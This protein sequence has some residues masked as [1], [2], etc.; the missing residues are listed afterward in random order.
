MALN[1]LCTPGF[2][3]VTSASLSLEHIGQNLGEPMSKER[4]IRGPLE[5]LLASGGKKIRH[6]L[7]LAFNEWLRV[8]PEKAEIISDIVNLLHTASLLIDDIQDSSKLRRGRPVAHSV[9][10]VAQTINS[11]NY[12]YFLAQQKLTSLKSTCANDIF[13]EELLNLHR[14]QGM[15][16]YWRDTLTCPT[17]EQYIGMVLD[18]TG[19]L[20]RLAVRLMQLESD[21]TCDCISLTNTLGAI[22]QIRDDILNLKARAYVKNKGFCEDITEGKFSFPVIHSIRSDPSN[23]QL[24]SI[25]RQRSDDDSLKAYAVDYIT[26]TGSF[27]YSHEKLGSLIAEAGVMVGELD[28][29]MGRSTGMWEFL[30]LLKLD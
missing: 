23:K 10:G 1:S 11:A 26:S 21:Q 30:G 8:P 29:Q 16:L 12:T 3:G 4:I 13:V 6:Q 28:A 19:G 2:Q 15:E 9:F 17:E 27:T 18:K 24:L 20:F 5:Y 7:M 22:F 14:G 25:L